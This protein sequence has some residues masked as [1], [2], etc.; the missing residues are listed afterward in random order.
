MQDSNA[1][2]GRVVVAGPPVQAPLLYT[3]HPLSF[4]GGFDPATGRIIDRQHPLCGAHSTGAVLALPAGRGSSTGSAVLLEAVRAGTAPAALIVARLD[5]IL[6]LGLLVAEELYQTTRMLIVLDPEDFAR[7]AHCEAV[8]I[9]PTGW[10]Y[11][12]SV[13]P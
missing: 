11:G 10:V 3:T 13:R 6:A 2:Q 5:P 4:W 8:R 7:L 1:W 9:E 12:Q